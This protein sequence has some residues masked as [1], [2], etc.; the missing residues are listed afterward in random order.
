MSSGGVNPDS[1]GREY[2]KK[3]GIKFRFYEQKTLERALFDIKIK[4]RSIRGASEYYNIPKSTLHD[5]L[6]GK[7]VNSHGGQTLISLEE[8]KMFA[9][10]IKTFSE[11]GF[12]MTR[13][14]IRMLVRDYLNRKGV[15]IKKFP[16]NLPGID[17]FYGFLRR[18]NALTQRLAQNIKR[19]RANITREIV[20]NY[21]DNLRKILE[22]VPPSHIVNYDETNLTDDPGRVKVLCRRGS[23][24][25]ERII[26]SSKASTSVMMS[27]SASGTLLPP[28]IVYKSV[29]L[30]PTWIEGGPEGSVYNRTKSGWFDA[31][32]FEDWFDKILLPYFKKL[33][34]K[35][36]LLGDNLASHTSLHVLQS[37]EANN[38]HF[39]LL[40]PNG[41]HLLQPLDVAFFAPF[42]KSWRAILTAWKTKNRG[43]VPKSEFPRLLKTAIENVSNLVNN[44]K[45]GFRACG[46]VPLDQDVVLKKIPATETPE[47]E[48]ADQQ[49]W[50]HTLH[51]FLQE[52]RLATTQDVQKKRGKKLKVPPG[53]GV[54]SKDI[55]KEMDNFEESDI[56]ERDEE[57]M[58]IENMSGED[59]SETEDEQAMTETGTNQSETVE[60][61]FT[62]DIETFLLVKFTAP[63]KTEKYYV[64]CVTAVIDKTKEMY[65]VNFLRKQDSDKMGTYFTYPSVKDESI[66]DGSQISKVLKMVKDLRRG[67][68]QFPCLSEMKNI[69]LE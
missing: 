13:M 5:H 27:I 14:D 69:K 10:G 53:Q 24:R 34:G 48:S 3:V 4:K 43:C 25:V 66:I 7:S 9:E 40:P 12:P 37:C 57:D 54:T 35:K 22:D 16:N 63:K 1:M 45:S 47:N 58:V 44:I 6:K 17:W 39:V 29:H 36:I 19:C 20:T 38:I 26:D 52:S 42:K 55:I 21:F 31:A 30:Y 59:E 65:L 61:D 67:R 60:T 8:E 33:P 56:E 68:Y 11:W 23:K 18:N 46:I 50:T 62:V 2:K 64:G 32:S 51:E 49:R 41:T 28:Y 15:T